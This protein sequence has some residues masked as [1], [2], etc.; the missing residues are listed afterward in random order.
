MEETFQG[1]LKA[2]S[3]FLPHIKTVYPNCGLHHHWV[4]RLYMWG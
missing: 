3:G 1:A 4:S 2:K